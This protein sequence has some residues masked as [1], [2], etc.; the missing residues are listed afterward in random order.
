[1]LETSVIYCGDCLTKLK[2]I[3]NEILGATRPRVALS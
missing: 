2:D 1:M 3:P